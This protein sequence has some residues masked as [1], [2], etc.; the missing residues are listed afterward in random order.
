MQDCCN[1]E[2]RY[3]TRYRLL[4]LVRDAWEAFS[5]AGNARVRDWKNPSH[6]LSG[7]WIDPE[8][9]RGFKL[10]PSSGATLGSFPGG[11]NTH[12]NRLAYIVS[13]PTSQIAGYY[14]YC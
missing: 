8:S 1:G 10:Q 6:P 3:V 7:F 2:A 4:V 5:M 9:P 13:L 12:H 14:R 11:M